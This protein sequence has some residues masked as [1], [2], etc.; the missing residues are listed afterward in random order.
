MTLVES[1]NQ[2]ATTPTFPPLAIQC[3]KVVSLDNYHVLD[4][5]TCLQMTETHLFLAY[6]P[7]YA[8]KATTGDSEQ[9]PSSAG[10]L[11]AQ[12][13]NLNETGDLTPVEGDEDFVAGEENGG[14]E[15]IDED[16]EDEDEV[17]YFDIDDDIAFDPNGDDVDIDDDDMA[18]IQLNPGLQQ[19][20]VAAIMAQLMN[21][22]QNGVAIDESDDDD[23][24]PELR[25]ELRFA[26]HSRLSVLILAIRLDSYLVH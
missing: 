10:L 26:H 19:Q 20:E 7:E 9:D 11:S 5:V 17:E 16:D 3:C 15:D 24:D 25:C 13:Q 4:Q 22:D 21:V 2:P 6:H 8:P 12:S 23:W 14:G 1:D 18:L